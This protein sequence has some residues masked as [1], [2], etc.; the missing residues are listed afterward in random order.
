MSENNHFLYKL[1]VG[2][3]IGLALGVAV[4][5]SFTTN[6]IKDQDEEEKKEGQNQQDKFLDTDYDKILDLSRDEAKGRFLAIT[7][8]T[9]NL[10]L[11][12]I[13]CDKS[14]EGYLR[15]SFKFKGGDQKF[16]FLNFKGESLDFVRV[17]DTLIDQK[18]DV[19]KGNKIFI[20]VDLLTEENVVD[21]RFT[22]TYR[23]DGVGLHRSVD[24]EDNEVY[25]HTQFE[26]FNANKW[27]PCFD[28][29]DIKAPLTFYSFSPAAWKI[30][31]WEF[32]TDT[33]NSSDVYGNF[34]N[35]IGWPADITSRFTEEDNVIFRKFSKTDKIS[36]YLYAFIVGP[37][38][39]V[40]NSAVNA[41]DYVPMR[42]F[43]R[44][45]MMKYVKVKDL[46]RVT[47]AGMDYYKYF[48]GCKYPFKKYDQIYW[49][50][51][52]AGAMENVGCVTITEGYLKRG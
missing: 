30:V 33:T 35:L 26:S 43:A 19:F 28:Q 25:M 36:T 48:F 10:V 52:N 15:V 34:M 41:N 18:Q 6:K 51:F 21:I 32:E 3:A 7:D 37:Y 50:E 20:P 12:F 9:Y 16:V 23:R 27:F 1:G 44:K 45:S 11:A 17:N 14:Y 5:K 46:F 42:V 4:W 40:R 38:E 47:M 13:K 22:G 29:P 49:Y 39:Y 24:P 2:V 8:V 31:T